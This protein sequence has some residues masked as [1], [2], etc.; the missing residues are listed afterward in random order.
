MCVLC[1]ISDRKTR[2][3]V[4]LDLLAGKKTSSDGADRCQGLELSVLGRKN[5][6][7]DRFCEHGIYGLFELFSALQLFH[8]SHNV[9]TPTNSNHSKR[10]MCRHEP[11][12]EQQNLY[13]Q[14]ANQNT[15][16]FFMSQKLFRSL[17]V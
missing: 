12:T 5:K 13:G 11:C 6:Q 7:T 3:V 4:D 16:I 1:I 2:M 9:L 8:V 14:R 17:R 15:F 10:T